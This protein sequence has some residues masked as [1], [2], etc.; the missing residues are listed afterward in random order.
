MYI[1]S[2]IHWTAKHIPFTRDVRSQ[3]QP[4]WETWRHYKSVPGQ[5]ARSL[6]GSLI[7]RVTASL[8]PHKCIVIVCTEMVR[9]QMRPISHPACQSMQIKQF[10]CFPG[11]NV[12][13]IWCNI[14]HIGEGNLTPS[15]A[16]TSTRACSIPVPVMWHRDKLKYLRGVLDLD[17]Y[18]A[19]TYIDPDWLLQT[20]LAC[21]RTQ[22]Q[23]LGRVWT[24]C[25][26]INLW[27]VK[28]SH[29]IH[30]K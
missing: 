12:E 19:Q 22:T 6:R 29:Y 25:H 17:T 26:T 13:H 8:A 15:L 28:Y 23:L 24:A 11:F 9:L 4:R 30:C 16:H 1:M 7:C 27:W 10:L 21:Q 20:H 18:L 5:Q 2:G 3:R 14:I